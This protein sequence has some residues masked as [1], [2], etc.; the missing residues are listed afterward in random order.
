MT[1]TLECMNLETQIFFEEI[2]HQKIFDTCPEV[3]QNLDQ[4][5]VD[6]FGL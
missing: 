2:E 5:T 6:V 1:R 4:G 3:F